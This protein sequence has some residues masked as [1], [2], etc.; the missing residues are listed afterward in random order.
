MLKKEKKKNKLLS[1]KVESL[2]ISNKDIKSEKLLENLKSILLIKEKKIDNLENE[3]LKTKEKSE[4]N[5]IC[6]DDNQF[7]KLIMKSENKKKTILKKTIPKSKKYTKAFAYRLA[8]KSDIYDAIDGNIIY[9]WDEKTSFTSNIISENWI[10][11]TGYFVDA[12]WV[13]AKQELW[14][15]KSNTLKR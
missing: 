8:I 10:K 6:K 7:P 11:I 9:T 15:K 4:K 12:K 14:I 1:Q 13:H 3:I 2:K 5:T